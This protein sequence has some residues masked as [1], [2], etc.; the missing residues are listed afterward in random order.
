MMNSAWYLNV[1]RNTASRSA[2]GLR[3]GSIPQKA[4]VILTSRAHVG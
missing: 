4:K 2:G 3:A 1:F